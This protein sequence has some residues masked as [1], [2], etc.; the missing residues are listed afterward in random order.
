MLILMSIKKGNIKPKK[1]IQ[2]NLES[3][4]KLLIIAEI[5]LVKYLLMLV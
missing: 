2:D 1:V 4:K 3:L 5:L